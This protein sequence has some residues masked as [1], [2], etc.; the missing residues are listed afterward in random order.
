MHC[1]IRKK[2]QVFL[3]EPI[4]H[5][6]LQAFLFSFRKSYDIIA[7]VRQFGGSTKH[8]LK[9]ITTQHASSVGLYELAVTIETKMYEN[10]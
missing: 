4:L 1:K 10:E 6:E 3:I 5:N 9:Q 8:L 2:S 7:Q